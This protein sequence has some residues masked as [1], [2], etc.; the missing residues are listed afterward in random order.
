MSDIPCVVTDVHNVITSWISC[1]SVS[2]WTCVHCPSIVTPLIHP[3][4]YIYLGLLGLVLYIPLNQ[5][6]LECTPNGGSSNKADKADLAVLL[7][8]KLY[9]FLYEC[10]RNLTQFL[11]LYT[12]GSHFIDYN[13]ESIFKINLVLLLCFSFSIPSL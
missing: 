9:C 13:K 2:S 5:L 7:A 6:I 12:S 10:I 4:F 3:R 8:L 11:M 1:Y